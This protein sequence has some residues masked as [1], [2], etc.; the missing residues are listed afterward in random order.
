M[1]TH[2]RA[3]GLLY[4][5]LSSVTS[6]LALTLFAAYDGPAGL[7]RALE[8]MFLAPAIVGLLLFQLVIALPAIVG[9]WFVIRFRRWARNLLVVISAVNVLNI[10]FG[11][12]LSMY[13]FW[14]LLTPETEF[15]FALESSR[16]NNDR[17]ARYPVRPPRP[18]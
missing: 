2:V 9:G 5:V 1:E 8:P 17:S 12:L 18:K 4:I 13:A 15:L 16:H 6:M 3:T 10:P 14:A 11:T 7:R